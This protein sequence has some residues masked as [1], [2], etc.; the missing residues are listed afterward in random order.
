MARLKHI[1]VNM[2]QEFPHPKCRFGSKDMEVDAVYV[3][4][5]PNP[6]K[7]DD[8]EPTFEERTE[9][10]I[11]CGDSKPHDKDIIPFTVSLLGDFT[12]TYNSLPFRYFLDPSVDKIFPESGNQNGGTRVLVNKIKLI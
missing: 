10:C 1:D 7:I 4:C 3:K 2:V 6:R 11:Q 5:T 12:D 8:P 9:I